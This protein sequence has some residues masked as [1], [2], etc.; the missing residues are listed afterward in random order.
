MADSKNEATMMAEQLVIIKNLQNIL[1]NIRKN[2]TDRRTQKNYTTKKLE[3]EEI[4]NSFTKTD[5]ILRNV[6]TTP[7]K[8]AKM[9]ELSKKRNNFNHGEK[10]IRISKAH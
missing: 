9:I 8:Y 6:T 7:E 5:A 10:T 3:I 1:E 2:P 4:I